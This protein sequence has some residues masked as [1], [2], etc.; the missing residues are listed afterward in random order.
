MRLPDTAPPPSAV[1]AERR[2]MK[3][4]MLRALGG[5]LPVWFLIW[6]LAIFGG[7]QVPALTGAADEG[8]DPRVM[9]PAQANDL[10]KG[11]NGEYGP[12]YE[13]NDSA[14]DPLISPY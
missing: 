5:Q 10:V 6:A 1:P 9:T 12:V 11:R 8:I 13:R 3:M 14:F 2:K 7:T 4:R